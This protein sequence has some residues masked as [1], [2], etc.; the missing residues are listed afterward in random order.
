MKKLLTT[1]EIN[2]FKLDGAIVLRKK[3]DVHWIEKLKS[4]IDKDIK[5]PSPR[6]KSHTTQKNIPA[7]LEDYWTWDLVPEFKDFV[8]N[9]PVSQIASELMSAKKVNLLMDNWFLREAGAKSSSPFHHD[10]SYFDVDGTICILWLPLEPTGKNEGVAWVKGS[11]LWNKLF[12]R[13]RFKDGH[14]VE[15]NESI[16]NGKKYENPPDI[17]ANKDKYEF[18]QWDFE[19]GDCAIFDMRTL[20]G[21]LSSSIP[22]RTL[23]RYTLRVAKE[24][25]KIS[26]V[27]DWTSYTYRQAMKDAGYKDGD[28]LGGKMFPTLYENI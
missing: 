3:F 1:K 18:L 24:G 5:S 12:L 2:D 28:S 8:F 7:Y 9:S 14:K 4:G 16:I 10:I 6:F 20:H 21:T 22:K 19:L 25:A 26:Y 15:G 27:G 17:L 11:H 13:V 23:S